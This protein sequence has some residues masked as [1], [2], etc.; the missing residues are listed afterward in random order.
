MPHTGIFSDSWKI[1]KVSPLFKKD[2]DKL[3]SNY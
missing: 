2:N 1:S 3:F